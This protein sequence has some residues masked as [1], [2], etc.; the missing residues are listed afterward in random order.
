MNAQIFSLYLY[1]IKNNEKEKDEIS[2]DWKRRSRAEKALWER[3]EPRAQNGLRFEFEFNASE[4]IL[5]P[6]FRQAGL[7]FFVPYNYTSAIFLLFTHLTYYA[8]KLIIIMAFIKL[9]L[10]CRQ[11]FKV[12]KTCNPHKG[13]WKWIFLFG[14]QLN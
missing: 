8:Y 11:I 1:I 5:T 4:N 3:L 12:M 9:F 7:H 2:K 10:I 13:Q 6:V 14:G